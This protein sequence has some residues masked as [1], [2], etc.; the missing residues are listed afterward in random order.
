M[1][2][3]ALHVAESI[4]TDP[5]AGMDRYPIPDARPAVHG[6]RRIQ[7]HSV[8]ELDSRGDGAVRSHDGVVADPNALAD[9]GVCADGNVA[10]KT[11]GTPDDRRRMDAAWCDGR[12]M[13]PREQREQRLLRLTDDD[14]RRN[15]AWRLGQIGGHE[16][17]TS[18]ARGEHWR[19][20]GDAE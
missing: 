12:A 5:R 19:I 14:P 4:R 9:H 20:L 16:D 7:V 18:L 11:D 6:D 1:L 17:D 13:K 15:V 3:V 2:A 10:S 8:A